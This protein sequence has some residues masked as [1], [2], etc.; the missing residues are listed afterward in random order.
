MIGGAEFLP[1]LMALSQVLKIMSWENWS[2]LSKDSAVMC[3]GSDLLVMA[4]VFCKFMSHNKAAGIYLYLLMFSGEKAAI[5]FTF[6]CFR[7][8][9]SLL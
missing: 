9:V 2:Q 1:F 3:R 6:I 4:N 7:S 5:Y 8:A